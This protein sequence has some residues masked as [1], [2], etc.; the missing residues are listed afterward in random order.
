MGFQIWVNVPTANK[1]DDPRYGTVP[2][3]QIPTLTDDATGV[4]VRV[5][6]G[7]Y[8]GVYGDVV[9]PFQTVADVQIIDVRLPRSGSA[10]T[11]PGIPECMDNVLVV[12]Y[13]GLGFINPPSATARQSTSQGDDDNHDK[14]A[15]AS[16]ALSKMATNTVAHLDASDDERWAGAANRS[17]H[18]AAVDDSEEG[19]G[20][21]VFAG[22]RLNEPVAWDGA[23]VMSLKEDL[24]VAV[25]ERKEGTLLRK[26]VPWDYR[27]IAEKPK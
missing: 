19:A 25:K 10:F 16:A 13:R 20:F 27:K 1:M 24:D 2:P 17:F 26:R 15:N 6:A 5:L 11:H 7:P 3:E 4:T 12:C 18:L 23:I 14:V 21:L 22:K 9:G 8:G